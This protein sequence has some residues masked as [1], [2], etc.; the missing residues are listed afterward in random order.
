VEDLADYEDEQDDKESLLDK[1]MFGF[2]ICIAL[3][4]VVIT[5]ICYMP[6]MLWEK[7]AGGTPLSKAATRKD[8]T[9]AT[10]DEPTGGDVDQARF[11]RSLRRHAA[12]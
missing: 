11:E 1:I 4:I 12:H 6:A 7:I 5:A 10:L 8:K 3:L 2:M 9:C